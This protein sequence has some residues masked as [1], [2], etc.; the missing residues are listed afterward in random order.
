MKIDAFF[1][2]PIPPKALLAK[3]KELLS[4]GGGSA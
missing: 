1:D 2:K 3:I 4:R